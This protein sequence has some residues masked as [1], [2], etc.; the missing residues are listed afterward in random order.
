MPK[1]REAGATIYIQEELSD[2]RLRCDEI[3]HLLV[4]A[5]DLVHASSQRDHLYAVAGDIIHAMP[6]ALLKLE[7]ALG[8]ASMAV[9]KIDYEEQ[10]QILR[11]EK[12]DE[13]ERV[14]EEVR[15]RIPHRTGRVEFNN[16]EDAMRSIASAASAYEDPESSA[17]T[18]RF[19][20]PAPVGDLMVVDGLARL[21]FGTG[22][23][24]TSS[25]YGKG[26]ILCAR[27]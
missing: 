17:R 7:R 6:E 11:P 22:Y 10:R 1:H 18:V 3:K 12:V 20:V 14:L 13:L 16:A 2:A 25:G 19:H 4:K 9:N 8:A 15:I 5:L 21:A 26:V 23:H 24:L 27:R